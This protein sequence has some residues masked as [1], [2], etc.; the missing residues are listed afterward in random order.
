MAAMDIDRLGAQS[1]ANIATGAAALKG[2]K[3]Y[4]AFPHASNLTFH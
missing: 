1:V 2:L 4:A 3:F